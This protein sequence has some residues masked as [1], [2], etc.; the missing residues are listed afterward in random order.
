MEKTFGNGDFST[1]SFVTVKIMMDTC[2]ISKT[3]PPNVIMTNYLGMNNTNTKN[4]NK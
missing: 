2:D 1:T 3:I 4:G